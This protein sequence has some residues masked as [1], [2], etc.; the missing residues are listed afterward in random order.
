MG[1]R[2]MAEMRE[3]FVR[4]WM[5]KASR[6]LRTAHAMLA[7][8]DPPTDIVCF[9]AQQCVEKC[10]KAFL[11]HRGSHVDKTHDLAKLLDDCCSLD[12]TFDALR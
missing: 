10:L 7:E 4:R 1:L 12:A 11:T 5:I 8:E 9:H 3:T 6:D 2:T